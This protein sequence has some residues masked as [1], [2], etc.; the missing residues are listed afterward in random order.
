MSDRTWMQVLQEANWFEPVGDHISLNVTAGTPV[1]AP[2]GANKALVQA[3]GQNA[4]YTLVGGTATVGTATGF[5]LKAGDP[6]RQIVL[7]ASTAL[8]IIAETG[9]SVVQVQWGK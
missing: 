3:L 6:P 5:Q 4:R 7:G 9:T 8:S 2:T 1:A